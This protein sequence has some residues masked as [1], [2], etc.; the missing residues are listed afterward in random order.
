[1]IIY[2]DD[3]IVVTRRITSIL[4]EA[5][6]PQI[7]HCDCYLYGIV[8]RK[9]SKIVD[10]KYGT[11]VKLDPCEFNWLQKTITIVIPYNINHGISSIDDLVDNW[12]ESVEAAFLVLF[13]S[14]LP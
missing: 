4:L 2:E 13:R 12:Y 6:P 9:P 11:N 5:I 14:C 10:G 7:Q 8:D 1:M 3:R